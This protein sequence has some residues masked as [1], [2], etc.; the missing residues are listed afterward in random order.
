MRNIEK[1]IYENENGERVEFSTR[2][3]YHV[4]DTDGLSTIRNEIYTYESVG[5]DGAGYVGN[6]ILSRDIEITGHFRTKN[7]DAASKARR[8]LI[9]VLNPHLSA[10]LIYEYGDFTRVISCNAMIISP[11]RGMVLTNF[12]IQFNCLDPFWRELTETRYIIAEWQSLFRFPF[13]FPMKFGRHSPDLI[14]EVDNK[15]D[16]ATGIRIMFKA[17]G[18]V[19]DPS[20]MNVHTYE[21]IRFLNISMDG[22]DVLIVDTNYGQK[23]VTLTHPN[24][25][26]ENMINEI[27]IDSTF[28]QLP[29]GKSKYTYDADVGKD[30]LEVVITHNTRYLGV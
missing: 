28:L 6:K 3:L 24:G 27:D 15:G 10:K 14:V 26:S 20:L 8:Y 12:K 18:S 5:M 30:N 21:F 29:V 11:R 7:K 13:K 1:L 23:G 22:G 25:T 9:Y 16:V 17:L 4:N 2:S 19:H